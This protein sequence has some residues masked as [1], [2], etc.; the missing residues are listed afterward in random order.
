MTRENSM[1]E[2]EKDRV[3]TKGIETKERVRKTTEKKD[4][5]IHPTV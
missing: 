4:N 5:G 1:K 2:A 3:Q